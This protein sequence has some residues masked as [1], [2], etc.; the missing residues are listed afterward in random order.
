MSDQGRLMSKDVKI[1]D[2][3]HPSLQLLRIVRLSY[4][5]YPQGLPILL[6]S[7]MTRQASELVI[8][9]DRDLTAC[10]EKLA[11]IRTIILNDLH[12]FIFEQVY[13]SGHGQE[14]IRIS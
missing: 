1:A 14:V 2:T 3:R 12:I 9:V 10:D 5:N 11:R 4:V 6:A 8:E 7:H 13:Q